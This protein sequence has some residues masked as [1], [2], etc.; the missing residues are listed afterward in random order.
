LT[1]SPSS[2]YVTSPRWVV[3]PNLQVTHEAPYNSRISHPFTRPS[4]PR[5]GCFV[6]EFPEVKFLITSRP[7]H[8]SGFRLLPMVKATNIFLLHS[9]KLSLVNSDQTQ[10]VGT[11]GSPGYSK[12]VTEGGA[13]GVLS[14]DWGTS[15][16][17]C[18]DSLRTTRGALPRSGWIT[19]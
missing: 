4:Y 9:V 16:I 3:R 15:R 19:F 5:L 10:L 7:D 2:G 14:I 17:C 11:C 1:S 18:R 6:V 12:R 13:F 8:K